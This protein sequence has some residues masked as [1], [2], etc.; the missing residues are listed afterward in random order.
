MTRRS[1]A[2]GLARRGF[3]LVELLVAVAL[4]TIIVGILA[5]VSIQ[6][7][8]AIAVAALREDA[9]RTAIA[10][11]GDV[12]RDVAALVPAST[13]PTPF[14]TT[15]RVLEIE[16]LDPTT[17]R[18][19]LRLF[20]T[21]RAPE[22]DPATGKHDLVRGLVEWQLSPRVS[23]PALG[24]DVGVLTR[25]IVTW[26][27]AG[28][29]AVTAGPAPPPAIATQ[30]VSFQVEWQDSTANGQY[31]GPDATTAN[32]ALFVRDGTMSITNGPNG[33]VGTATT[34]AADLDA[35]PIGAELALLRPSGAPVLVLIRKRPPPPASGQVLFN[36]RL[37]D[38]TGVPFTA[39]RGPP[40]LRVTVVVPFGRGPEAGTARFS[41]TF[42]VPR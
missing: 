11:L 7:Q 21:V 39:F 40:A 38:Q 42:P 10:I 9:A 19:R 16:A 15:Q 33:T 4:A 32:G 1:G 35:L 41:R 13:L 6:A 34:G 22:P 24:P 20:T 37:P 27:R 17:P 23:D 2:R 12:E 31:K 8:R 36:D 29:A 14:P 28:D 30:V 18:D 25:Q 26:A 3:T 5:A